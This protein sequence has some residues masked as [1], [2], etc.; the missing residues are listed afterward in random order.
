MRRAALVALIGL[1]ALGC[2]ITRDG[3]FV[4]AAVYRHTERVPAELVDEIVAAV[5][6]RTGGAV[7]DEVRERIAV[8]V[9][10]TYVL[11][12]WGT[13]HIETAIDESSERLSFGSNGISANMTKAIESAVTLALAAGTGGAS[14]IGTTA[15]P[16]IVDAL[17]PTDPA[18]PESAPAPAPTPADALSDDQAGAD[19]LVI[20]PGTSP[21][22]VEAIRE[23][24]EAYAP[25]VTPSP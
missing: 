5:E 16:A 7:S 1:L 19:V 4:G 13:S 11:R 14:L 2:S 20:P 8:I 15:A 3:L 24:L 17:E 10:E 18:A 9:W 12:T 23:M 25:G 6:A 22:D 21:E